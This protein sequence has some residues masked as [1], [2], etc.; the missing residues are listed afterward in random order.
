MD[1]LCVFM[2]HGGVVSVSVADWSRPSPERLTEIAVGLEKD[3]L[4]YAFPQATCSEAWFWLA[5]PF[6]R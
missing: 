4:D 3:A 5:R 1:D 2:V 6:E